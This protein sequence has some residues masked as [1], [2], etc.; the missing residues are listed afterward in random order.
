M[1][2][3]L[4][5]GALVGEGETPPAAAGEGGGACFCH[6]TLMYAGDD[7]FLEGCLPFVEAGIRGGEP[8]LVAVAPERTGQLR[9]ALGEDAAEVGF[10]DMHAL[11][12]NPARI[13]PAW[14]EFLTEHPPVE[15]SVRGIG[16]PIW[17]GRSHAE[18]AE[19]ERHEALLNWA[20][21]GGRPW[22]LLCPYDVDALD[23]AVL[24]GALRTH[25]FI[26]SPEGRARSE[27]FSQRAPEP[28]AGALPE[29]GGDVW[30]MP[31]R[32]GEL[33]QLRAELL[34]WAA[35]PLGDARAGELVLAV[36][37][38]TSNSVR[39]GGGRGSL[40][41]WREEDSLI[42]EVCD[43]GRLEDPL[44]GRIRPAPERNAGRGLWITNQLCDL[45]QIRSGEQGTAVRVHVRLGTA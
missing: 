3:E 19:C 34:D 17:P 10:L 35:V 32:S 14:R 13:I 25:P 42:C 4:P 24:E 44:A 1:S 40:R 6:E 33:G 15:G 37:E 38:L 7:G 27:H 41:V 30:S 22:R 39:H 20:F 9:E 12:A 31:F 18:L 8:V 45:V 36:N 21:G 23:D 43:A 26:S 29:P 11:G 2:D 16:E 28:F 5:A